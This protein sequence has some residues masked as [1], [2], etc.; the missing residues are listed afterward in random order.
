M[1]GFKSFTRE[2]LEKVPE[3]P[4]VYIVRSSKSFKR[5]RGR[6][7]IVYIGM[8]KNLRRRVAT[9][10]RSSGRNA[11]P[12]F[13]ALVLAGFHLRFFYQECQ[14]PHDVEQ[15]ILLFYEKKHLE[16]PPLNHAGGISAVA[17][18]RKHH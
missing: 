18:G 15:K 14:N 1:R 12:R 3:K 5:L 11:K 2:T 7:N 6:T 13:E 17:K 16:L 10:W 4:G 9:F 8:A